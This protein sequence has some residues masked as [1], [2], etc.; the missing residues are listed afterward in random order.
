MQGRQGRGKD[1]W[2]RPSR[3][4][5]DALNGSGKQRTAPQRPPGMARLDTPPAVQRV[6]RPQRQQ[7]PPKR[8]RRRLLIALIVLGIGAMLVFIIAYGLVNYFIGIG[9]SAGPANTAADFLVN[10]QS[11]TYDQAYKDLDGIITVQMHPQDF[12]TMAQA[13][14]RC[15]GSITGFNEVA[16]SAV[17]TD[18]AQTFTYSMTRSKL[19]KPYQLT[20][21][22][23]KDPNG[24]WDITKFVDGNG[25]PNDLGPTPP[26]CS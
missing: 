1:P 8:R 9:N 21:T 19:A 13:N 18:N 17:V 16:G 24:N 4:N 7:K 23:Q 15:Y 22:L 5:N 6:G 14:D 3:D 20:L 11:R 2:N 25:T 12:L 10:L 26:T